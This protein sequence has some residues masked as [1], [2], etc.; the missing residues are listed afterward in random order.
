M[1][2]AMSSLFKEEHVGLERVTGA[3]EV[4]VGHV[5]EKNGLHPFL[6]FKNR[7]A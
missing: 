4:Y 7:F 6:E 5:Y 3:R 1:N 2:E